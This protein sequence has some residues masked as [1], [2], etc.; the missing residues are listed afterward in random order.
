LNTLSSSAWKTP[1]FGGTCV[2]A[3]TIGI[4]WHVS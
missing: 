2:R 4:A 1:V 3:R